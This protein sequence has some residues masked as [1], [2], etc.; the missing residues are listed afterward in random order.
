M[1]KLD[2]I[3][4]KS[5]IAVKILIEQKFLFKK[6]TKENKCQISS[7]AKCQLSNL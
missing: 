3:V 4:K 6:K 2:K 1:A 7:I 5:I